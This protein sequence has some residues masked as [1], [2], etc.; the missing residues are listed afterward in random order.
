MLDDGDLLMPGGDSSAIF[1]AA[2]LRP[3]TA[4]F[5]HFD[6]HGAGGWTITGMGIAYPMTYPDH[7]VPVMPVATRQRNATVFENGLRVRVARLTGHRTTGEPAVP[8]QRDG[9][10]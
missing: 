8:R 5:S 10:S 9:R 3:V 7:R 1:H 4:E 6:R 2:A